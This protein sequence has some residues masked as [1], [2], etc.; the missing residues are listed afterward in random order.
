MRC[1]RAASLEYAPSP[2]GP[3]TEILAELDPN[4]GATSECFERGRETACGEFRWMD[5][6]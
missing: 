1:V 3:L 4:G 6:L 5:A 2:L